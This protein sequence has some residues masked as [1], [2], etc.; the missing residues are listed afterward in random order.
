MMRSGA[1]PHARVPRETLAPPTCEDPVRRHVC[2]PGGG[3]GQTPGL[4][5][6]PPE[7]HETKARGLRAARATAALQQPEDRPS[8]PRVPRT[9]LLP[10]SLS[11]RS[12]TR[13]VCAAHACGLSALRAATRFLVSIPCTVASFLRATETSSVPCVSYDSEC[14]F[15]RLS[16]R[17][18]RGPWAHAELARAERPRG[19]WAARRHPAVLRPPPA[20]ARPW[21]GPW[22]LLARV[23]RDF[24]NTRGGQQTLLRCCGPACVLG[25]TSPLRNHGVG[26]LAVRLTFI[27]EAHFCGTQNSG[28]TDPFFQLFSHTQLPSGSQV[29]SESRGH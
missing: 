11:R 7:L 3:P 13:R 24:S 26:L 9:R 28:V 2:D 14:L 12:R 21:T 4:A 27:P 29:S 25:A 1:E 20:P 22:R 19:H 15:T 8:L 18:L 6:Q 10:K 16:Q 23:T 5:V 17:L